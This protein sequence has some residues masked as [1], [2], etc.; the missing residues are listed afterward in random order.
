MKD[1][2]LLSMIF[3]KQAFNIL[4]GINL[5]NWQNIMLQI[6]SLKLFKIMSMLL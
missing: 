4:R 5:Q 3:L 6:S 1:M 2:K